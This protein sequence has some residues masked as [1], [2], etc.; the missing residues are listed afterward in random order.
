MRY[1]L[2]T[3][4]KLKF[5]PTQESLPKIYP[6][7]GANLGR[8]PCLKPRDTNTM[9]KVTVEDEYQKGKVSFRIESEKAFSRRLWRIAV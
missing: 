2:P 5:I 3:Q 8:K 1:P 4:Q 9:Y 6:L 7:P